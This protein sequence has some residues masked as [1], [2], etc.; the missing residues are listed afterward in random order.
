M[1]SGNN[2]ALTFDAIKT[3]QKQDCRAI[4][5]HMFENQ[6][7]QNLTCVKICMQIA[8]DCEI[9][10]WERD[11]LFCIRWKLKPTLWFL[12]GGCVANVN[13]GIFSLC[14]IARCME[15]V[16]E[17]KDGICSHNLQCRQ[18]EL[19]THYI[20]NLKHIYPDTTTVIPP[21]PGPNYR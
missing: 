15:G 17:M 10:G 19:I 16:S 11:D 12:P 3:K 20:D 2:Y 14:L 21:W 5:W 13:N 1:W 18:S 4:V 8:E 6:N 9:I 7:E